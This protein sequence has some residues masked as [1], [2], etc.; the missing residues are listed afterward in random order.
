MIEHKIT[1]SLQQWTLEERSVP[2]R[3]RGYIVAKLIYPESEAEKLP[4]L[5]LGIKAVDN[6]RALFIYLNLTNEWTAKFTML[7]NKESADLLIS[8]MSKPLFKDFLLLLAPLVP[9]DF[10]I[11]KKKLDK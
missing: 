11:P 5:S 8:K 7:P 2:T 10:T 9:A 3:W 6:Q 1:G 4:F